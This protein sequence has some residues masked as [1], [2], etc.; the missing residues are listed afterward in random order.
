MKKRF[1]VLSCMLTA[2]VATLFSQAPTPLWGK[3]V[4]APKQ[5]QGCDIKIGGDGCLYI[6]GNAGTRQTDDKIT[7]GS[8][9]LA[10]GTQYRGT[11]DN[12]KVQML[13]LS[14]LSAD[15]SPLWTVRSDDA[16]VG[17][18][19]QWLQPV[20]DGVV[21]F[22]VMRHT[23]KGGAY[24]PAIVD[25]AGT[26]YSLDWTLPEGV[27]SR[28]YIGIVA[29][30]DNDGRLQ[31]LRKMLTSETVSETIGANAIAADSNGSLWIAGMIKG[32]VTMAKADGTTVT[33]APQ[34]ADGDML[35][36][37]LDGDGYYQSH[38]QATGTA[39]RLNIAKLCW[40]D[41][42]MYLLGFAKGTADGTTGTVAIGGRDI[43]WDSSRESPFTA[44][45]KA[46]MT[47]DW[48]QL[49]PSQRGSTLQ[50]CGLT[51][52]KDNL[53]VTGTSQLSLT[54][55]TG[56]TLDYG[57]LTR[58]AMLL[59]IDKANGQLSDGHLRFD[60]Q[61][62]YFA[63]FESTD[64]QLYVLNHQGVVL[65]TYPNGGPMWIEQFNPA[66]LSAPV[67][68]WDAM[69]ANATGAQGIELNA[70]GTL[71]TMTRT[72]VVPNALCGSAMTVQQT[73]ADYAC[74]VC[75]FKLP[76]SPIVSG[77]S[78]IAHDESVNGKQ[79]VG[80]RYDLQGRRLGKRPVRGIWIENGRKYS[81]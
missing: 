32:Q 78:E 73:E 22:T 30:F 7:L 8:D 62:G 81:R 21:L 39:Q 17:S 16:E 71:F 9:L 36:V 50:W 28:H 23:D 37:K 75:A 24:S 66:D 10:T 44:A 2:C 18:N 1:M 48:L 53:W 68:S 33:L 6:T 61:T 34:Y 25:A 43:A 13:F 56:K 41:D 14:K 46:D 67:G 63:A 72:K 29:K 79:T 45:L 42:R 51:V 3:A 38:L 31:W 54:T 69:I 57:D 77:I 11:N 20:A 26:R 55:A 64:G 58:A 60:N 47:A 15:G 76:V 19:C 12:S 27:N 65:N 35:L 4:E 5:T 40:S 59:K 80:Q 49:Y 52:G 74:N 70:D